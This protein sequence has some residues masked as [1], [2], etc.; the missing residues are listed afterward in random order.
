[1][2]GGKITLGD[3]K[4]LSGEVGCFPWA[5][6]SRLK[7]P[8]S[9][10]SIYNTP[11]PSL[12]SCPLTGWV[13]GEQ[14]KILFQR[15]RPSS[16]TYKAQRKCNM[17]STPWSM[18]FQ[19][20]FHR[21]WV[22][23]WPCFTSGVYAP[24]W[25]VIEIIKKKRGWTLHTYSYLRIIIRLQLSGRGIYYSFIRWMGGCEGEIT[26]RFAT[27]GGHTAWDWQ[28]ESTNTGTSAVSEHIAES[29]WFEGS[30]WRKLVL[31]SLGK[32]TQAPAEEGG[33]EYLAR[34]FTSG[35]HLQCHCTPRWRPCGSSWALGPWTL[36]IWR[37]WRHIMSLLHRQSS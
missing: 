33:V 8:G 11:W 22:W 18:W 21:L 19:H 12:S 17:F 26:W 13:V 28:S 37:K 16:T 36:Q 7:D 4:I 35:T 32:E 23:L 14:G 20:A 15:I 24:A 29:Y 27:S 30:Q 2:D 34:L 3:M 9:S 6:Y 10:P 31:A 1:M 5:N 25:G